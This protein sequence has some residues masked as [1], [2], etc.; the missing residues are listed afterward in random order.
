[1]WV[2]CTGSR[3]IRVGSMMLYRVIVI[4]KWDN[5]CLFLPI[6]RPLGLSKCLATKDHIDRNCT[7]FST[8]LRQTLLNQDY[9]Y[10]HFIRLCSSFCDRLPFFL[11]II[12]IFSH[13]T[14]CLY[15]A[16]LGK[17]HLWIPNS[18]WAITLAL[19]SE[20]SGYRCLGAAVFPSFCDG[21][22]TLLK[23]DWCMFQIIT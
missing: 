21:K 6:P 4:A 11:F 13:K 3:W 17:D 9:P 2:Y 16:E 10:T 15:Q 7:P 19:F 14:G 1:M 5:A 18:H 22:V 20:F 12:S 8:G 23:H